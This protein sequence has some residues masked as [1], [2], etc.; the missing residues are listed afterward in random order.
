M[1]GKE[2]HRGTKAEGTEEQRDKVGAR[3]RAKGQGIIIQGAQSRLKPLL[4]S[5]KNGFVIRKH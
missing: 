3:S 5:F 1:K 2:R 4:Q